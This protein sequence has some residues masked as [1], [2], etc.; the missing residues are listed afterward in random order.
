MCSSWP[1]YSILGHLV[2][3]VSISRDYGF[4]FGNVNSTPDG[5]VLDRTELYLLNAELQLNPILTE[6]NDKLQFH[7]V[8]GFVKFDI[9]SL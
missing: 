6:K 1:E 4:L 2:Q 3:D 5:P 8:T 7:L 9:F